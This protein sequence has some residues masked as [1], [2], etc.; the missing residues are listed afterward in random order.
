MGGMKASGLG[1]RQGAEGIL[2]YTESQTVA[3]QQ[4]VPLAPLPGMSDE[5][6]ARGMTAALRAL[7]AGGVRR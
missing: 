3:A 4:L 1:R 7:K 6:W 2:K 5:T